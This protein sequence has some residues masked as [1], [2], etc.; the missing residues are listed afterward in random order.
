MGMDLY[1]QGLLCDL[2]KKLEHMYILVV[3]EDVD[4]NQMHLAH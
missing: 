3:Q 2:G 1:R 4:T